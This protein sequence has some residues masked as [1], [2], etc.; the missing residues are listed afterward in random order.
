MVKKHVLAVQAVNEPIVDPVTKFGG[1][2]IWI[3]SPQWPISRSTGEQMRFLGQFRLDPELFGS[4]PCQMAYLFMTDGETDVDGTWLPDG[5]EN[6]VIL[7]PGTP[8]GSYQER[9][10][11]P[12][13]F[14][15]ARDPDDG[16]TRV[17]PC[18]YRVHVSVG[19]DP[20]YLDE[21]AFRARGEWNAY[22]DYVRESKVGGT[23]AFL[24][25][26]ESPGPGA[27]R[28]LAQ[29]NSTLTP[30]GINFGDGGVGY[31]FLSSD[32]REARFLWQD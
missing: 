15:V 16:T 9:S 18:E 13:L 26:P 20:D 22:Y 2:P 27:W 14:D 11:G 30:C 8:P 24:Q 1:Q 7:Q 29:V 10:T 28:L 12:T 19:E 31:L 3:A 32:G 23:P 6:A 21:N 17:V 5:G 4:L 25:G